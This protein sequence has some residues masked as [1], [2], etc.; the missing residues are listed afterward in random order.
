MYLQKPGQ[1]PRQ[2]PRTATNQKPD[3][4]SNDDDDG[5]NPELQTGDLKTPYGS[6]KVK[7]VLLR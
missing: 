6:L 4:V 3:Q 7:I 1:K 5:R 2:K